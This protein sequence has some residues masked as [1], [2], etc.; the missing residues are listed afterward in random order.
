MKAPTLGKIGFADCGFYNVAISRLL[1]S[2]GWDV[3]RPPTITDLTIRKGVRYSPEMICYP[4]KVTLGN[5]IELLETGV[6]NIVTYNSQGFC[7]FTHFSNLYQDTLTKLGYDFRLFEIDRFRLFHTLGQLSGD[8]LSW[9]QILKRI[10]R[11]VKDMIRC[12]QE[13]EGRFAGQ[14]LKVMLTGEAYSLVVP[15]LNFHVRRMLLSRGIS[16]TA[17][18]LISHYFRKKFHLLRHDEVDL[19]ARQ[20]L[21]GPISGCAFESLRNSLYAGLNRYHGIIHMYPLT[22]MPETTVKS[23]IEAISQKH[24]LPLLTVEIDENLSHLNVATRLET[25]VEMVREKARRQERP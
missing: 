3:V 11:A 8:R 25:F 23:L 10:I 18:A 7:R 2:F 1:E 14:P 19:Q 17:P 12:E 6:K 24:G 22:C 20:L 21:N 16:T 15:E 5:I 4:Y 9:L 13:E